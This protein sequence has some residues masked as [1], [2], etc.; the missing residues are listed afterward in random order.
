[1]SKDFD[2]WVQQL[3]SSYWG[4]QEKAC[5]KLGELGDTRAVV[6]LTARLIDTF[7]SVREAANEAGWVRCVACEALGKLGDKRVVALLIMRLWDDSEEVRGVACKALE[8]L[9]AGRMVTAVV[10]VLNH[11]PEA[12]DALMKIVKERGVYVFP[13]LMV[14]LD[15]PDP[16]VRCAAFQA[17]TPICK[18][19]QEWLNQFLCR[20][21]LT[22]FEKKK[23]KLQGIG[24]LHLVVCR[25]CGK[26]SHAM[27]GVQEV[28]A[29]LDEKMAEEIVHTD[30]IVRV[31]A[32]KRETLF[33]LERVEIINASDDDIHRFCID[34]GNDG[35]LY[36]RKR[37][38][39]WRCV[40]TSTCQPSL[41]TRHI[42]ED[43][44]RRVEFNNP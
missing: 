1:M 23:T 18:L 25:A 3:N 40:V 22:R 36:R 29:V 37:R 33:D 16:F 20:S 10:G 6:P 43:T 42:L 19:L 44:F 41:N 35:D 15:N 21:C 17:L 24:T 38:K 9:R 13:P 31:N 39:K 34:I 30:G 26:A 28:V 7:Y 32:M 11:Q 12:C 2:Y 27:F 8:K 5:E 14:L 4:D